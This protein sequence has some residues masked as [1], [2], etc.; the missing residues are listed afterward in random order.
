MFSLFS[1][2]NFRNSVCQSA[3]PIGRTGAV[4]FFKEVLY[5]DADLA[6]L[7]RLFSRLLDIQG[8][9][10]NG[11]CFTLEEC[12]DRPGGRASGTC[13]AGSAI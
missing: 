9:F 10:R 12:G 13:A 3:L 8:S 4:R 7:W 5:V 11:T 2:V 1:V 6:D